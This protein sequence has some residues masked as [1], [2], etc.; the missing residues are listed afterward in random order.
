M[1]L[2]RSSLSAFGVEDPTRH[3]AV[4]VAESVGTLL[5]SKRPFDPADLARLDSISAE[6]GFQRLY[7]PVPGQARN[8]FLADTAANSLGWMEELGLN[9]D[10]PTDDSPYFF[11]LISPFGSSQLLAGDARS[12]TRRNVN[13]GSTRVLQQAM[14]TVS[15]LAIALFL[16]PFLART[17]ESRLR[18]PAA[19]LA[20]ASLYFAAIGA[21]FMLIETSL[22]QRFV[23]YLGHP[24]YATTV[25]IA[26][27]LIG[28]GVGSNTA[29]RVGISGLQRLGLLAPISVGLLAWGLP[30]LFS[31]TLGWPLAARVTLSCGLLAPLG[32]LLGLFFPLGMLRFGDASKPW[33]WA[34][35]GVFG[36]VA[37]VMSLALS[38]EFGFT[39]VALLGAVIYLL[40]W[41]CF[42]GQ[43][44]VA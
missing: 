16:F 15:V 4:V 10:P 35:N 11:H 19:H 30:P 44:S 31:A 42:Q 39:N 29:P 41:G 32:M 40:A 6:R 24:S 1:L 36:V 12:L 34:I 25:V 43:E 27:L 23:L 2:A 8:R 17:R 20:Q 33:Y 3:M 37:S 7:P 28:M 5:V 26:T 14:W 9:T 21:G 18:E 22:I 38:M 13:L